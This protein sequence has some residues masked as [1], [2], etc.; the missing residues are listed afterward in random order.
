[1]NSLVMNFSPNLKFHQW[2]L[3]VAWVLLLL[4]IYLSLTGNPIDTGDSFLYQD[5]VFHAIA[6]FV[7]MFWFAQI[8]HGNVKRNLIAFLLVALG[9]SLE[10]LQGLN[11]VRFYEVADMLANATGVVLG[12]VLTL[13]NAKNC[14]VEFE[15]LVFK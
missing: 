13:T 15:K 11:P 4:V 8:Y 14:L 6:Y 7:L 5:K 3:M 9:V 12:Y 2:W 10:F 1:M